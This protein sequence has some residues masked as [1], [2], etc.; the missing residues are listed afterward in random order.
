LGQELELSD[1]I[2]QFQMSVKGAVEEIPE[3]IEQQTSKTNDVDVI[4]ASAKDPKIGILILS[5]EIEK[6]MRTLL[7]SLGWLADKNY[8]S[9]HE[10]FETL[11]QKRL[12]PEHTMGSVRIFWQLRNEIVHGKVVDSESHVIRVLDIG[13]TLLRTLR[14]IP[15]ETYIVHH[16][17]VDLFSD[18]DCTTKI[19]GVKGLILETISPGG[20]EKSY[21]IYP[22]TK[23]D[24]VKGRQV[25]WE[26][27]LS[28]TWGRSWYI[29]P[30]TNEKKAAWRS[31]GEFVGRHAN[32]LWD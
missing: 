28:K 18:P 10:G 17:G 31:A 8:R 16:P 22:T 13:M 6:E 30:G 11:S 3:R 29:D 1:R 9:I 7:G 32:E 25:A 24:Y 27:N 23:T 14:A 5:S 4:E 21:R 19:Q 2:D 15:R 12:L 20:V 26:W